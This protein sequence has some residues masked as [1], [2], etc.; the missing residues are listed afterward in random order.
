MPGTFLRPI[1]LESNIISFG[2]HSLGT[3]SISKSVSRLGG[4]GLGERLR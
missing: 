2:G 3:M 1:F 4:A